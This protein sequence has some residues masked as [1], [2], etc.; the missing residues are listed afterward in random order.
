[1]TSNVTTLFILSLPVETSMGA[2]RATGVP[3]PLAPSIKYAK[4]KILQTVGERERESVC[5]G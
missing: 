2:P 1:M 3:N 4:E 5:Q